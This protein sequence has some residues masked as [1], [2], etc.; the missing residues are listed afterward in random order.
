MNRLHEQDVAPGWALVE[1]E[2][3]GSLEAEL[4]REI[5]PGHVLAPRKAWALAQHFEDDDVLF[6]LDDGSL[7]VVSLTWRGERETDPAF[8]ATTLFATPAEWVDS[9]T[10]AARATPFTDELDLHSFS[11][12]DAAGLVRDFLD[13]WAANGPR[14]VRIIHGKGIGAMQRLVH[15]ILEQHPAVTR[16]SLASDRAGWGATVATVERRA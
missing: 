6:G 4:A 15:E 14:Q 2:A 12:R 8:P 16:F 10:R 7:A 3:A 11:P 5:G 9:E 1:G 13:H